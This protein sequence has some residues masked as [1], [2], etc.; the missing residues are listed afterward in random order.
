MKV[1]FIFKAQDDAIS[2]TGQILSNF[3]RFLDKFLM[4]DN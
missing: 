2:E 1:K 4:S 3:S